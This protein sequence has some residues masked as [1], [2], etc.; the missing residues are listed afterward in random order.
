MI[1]RSAEGHPA[2]ASGHIFSGCKQGETKGIGSLR[3]IIEILHDCIYEH[4]RN[5]GSIVQT[6]SCRICIIQL[7]IFL[8]QRR[9]KA[10]KL[11]GNCVQRLLL[12]LLSF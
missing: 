7:P 10:L 1:G 3:L 5:Y 12:P 4:L 6:G 11:S 9:R 2:A 8:K